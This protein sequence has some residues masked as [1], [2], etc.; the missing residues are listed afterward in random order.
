MADD[1]ERRRCFYSISSVSIICGEYV[2]RQVSP[3]VMLAIFMPN[4]VD[5]CIADMTL[6]VQRKVWSRFITR[7]RYSA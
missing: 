6:K 3:I 2:L 5:V 1:D 7:S 4:F